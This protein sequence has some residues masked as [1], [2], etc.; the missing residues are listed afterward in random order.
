MAAE[1]RFR[2]LR[3]YVVVIVLAVPTVT[4]LA[5]YFTAVSFREELFE[6]AKLYAA[7]VAQ[8]VFNHVQRGFLVP[9]QERG[10]YVDLINDPEQLAEVEEI[11]RLATN[12][13]RVAMVYFLET[14][15]TVSFSTNREQI[16]ESMP[17]GNVLFE[18]AL[19]GV[20]SSALRQGGR[21]FDSSRIPPGIEL[22]ET[23]VPVYS[24]RDGSPPTLAGVVEVYQNTDE[25]NNAVRTSR[26][27]AALMAFASMG[28]L[29]IIFALI[30]LKADRVIQQ[31]EREILAS[32]SALQALSRDLERQVEERTRQLIQ[33]EKLASLGTLAA[34]VAHEINNPLAT[35]AACADGSLN[36]CER[37]AWLPEETREVQRYLETINEEVYR[38]KKITQNL[39]DFSRQS[40]S[41]TSEAVDIDRLVEHAMELVQ[42]AG[43]AKEVSLEADLHADCDSLVGD[44]TQ[45]RQIIHNLLSNSLAAVR[46]QERP[47]ILI[48]TRS[49]PNTV[50]LECLDNG[51]GIRRE[52]REKVFEPFFTTKPAGQGTGLGLAVCYSIAQRHGGDLEVVESTDGLDDPSWRELGGGRIRLTLPRQELLLP[53]RES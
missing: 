28:V 6:E 9:M 50:T 29:C 25:L 26:A 32:N 8:N 3:Y 39:L 7:A 38:C 27:H 37:E 31:R 52:H 44:P 51:P 45:I 53:E 30:T 15:G 2:L 20:C 1:K 5:A 17:S 18:R 48:R 34:G 16:G 36:R 24:E 4:G 23:Y 47:R 14:N 10:A 40:A 11:V 43:D 21:P 13:H 19:E 49:T 41:G 33:H 35:I 22:L 42:L 46:G 12:H